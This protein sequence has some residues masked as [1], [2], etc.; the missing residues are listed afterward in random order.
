M[1]V[2]QRV[3]LLLQC[4]CIACRQGHPVSRTITGETIEECYKEAVKDDWVFLR[5]DEVLYS[6]HLYDLIKLGG[7]N[8]GK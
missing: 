3:S 5:K 4:D 2:T 1:A 6:F 7:K 8:G